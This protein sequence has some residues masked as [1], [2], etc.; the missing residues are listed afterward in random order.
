MESAANVERFSGFADT[1]DANRPQPP[2][3]ITDILTQ[4]A[5][6]NKPKLVVDIGC[7]TGLATR[8]WSDKAKNIIGIEPNADMMQQAITQTKTIGD[9]PNIS[10][11]QATSS[12]TGL[13]DGCADIVTCSQSLHWMEPVSTFA[14]ISRIL[15]Y[16]G[17]F[18]SIDCDW[19]P[20][21]NMEAEIAYNTF[22]RNIGELEKKAGILKTVSRWAKKEHLSRIKESNYFRYTKEILVHNIE[23]GNAERLVGLALSFGSVASLFKMGYSEKDIGVDKLRQEAERVLGNKQ[24]PWYFSYRIRIGIK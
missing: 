7:G 24:I 20:T 15:R 16:G 21:I 10:Y 4:L 9:L 13:P 8:I 17:V 11:Q 3:I 23:S 22:M 14:E 6:C 19:P 18:A 12:N 5:E 2:L 1:Y